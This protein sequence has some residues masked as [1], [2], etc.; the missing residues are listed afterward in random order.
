[1]PFLGPFLSVPKPTM[2]PL[3][4]NILFNSHLNYLNYLNY[5]N[6]L[7]STYRTLLTVVHMQ[8][9][10]VHSLHTEFKIYSTH[11]TSS[12]LAWISNKLNTQ[13][14]FKRCISQ[15]ASLIEMI[16]AC[17]EIC[18]LLVLLFLLTGLCCGRGRAC[19][20]DS[21]SNMTHLW[22]VVQIWA[23]WSYKTICAVWVH[24]YITICS[25][26]YWKKLKFH[27]KCQASYFGKWHRGIKRASDIEHTMITQP[28][29]PSS[30]GHL[31][32]L[33]KGPIFIAITVSEIWALLQ[34]PSGPLAVVSNFQL[35]LQIWADCR[36]APFCYFD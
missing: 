35:F 1:M 2:C 24:E 8:N 11:M 20:Q 4:T 27:G 16:L 5:F 9:C 31:V 22:F 3:K 12:N 30:S 29:L 34:V 14:T 25:I 10:L 32:K 7:G 17:W 13:S 18:L 19:S 6:C 36:R 26:T 33:T 28:I 21:G 15:L 23:K